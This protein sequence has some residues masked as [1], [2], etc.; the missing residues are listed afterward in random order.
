MYL[1]RRRC[2]GCVNMFIVIQ[3]TCSR[4]KL[5][6][7]RE[8]TTLCADQAT[9]IILLRKYVYLPL[10]M[11]ACRTRDTIQYYSNTNGA[12]INSGKCS[13]VTYVPRIHPA[14]SFVQ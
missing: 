12:S 13:R 4:V 8:L 5:C 6:C 11:A 9:L 3:V 14:R 7:Q 10:Q 1:Q 2:F